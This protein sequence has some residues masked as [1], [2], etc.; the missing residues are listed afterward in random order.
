MACEDRTVFERGMLMYKNW[1]TI[2]MIGKIDGKVNRYLMLPLAM[3]DDLTTNVA[4]RLILG[5]PECFSETES[6]GP[7]PLSLLRKEARQASIHE[8]GEGSGEDH[9]VCYGVM[10]KYCIPT[11]VFVGFI[12]NRFADQYL[13]LP[14]ETW[15]GL[16]T[17]DLVEWEGHRWV[18]VDQDDE[19]VCVAPQECI[20]VSV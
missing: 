12:P 15:L 13:P 20:D 14:N 1:H 18:I 16:A 9:L 4:R 7:V 6:E 3:L 19:R 11:V 17:G 8:T 10:D 2:C 5:F